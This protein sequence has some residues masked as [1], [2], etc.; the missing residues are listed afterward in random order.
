MR[1]CSALGYVSG[2]CVLARKSAAIDLIRRRKQYQIRHY[3]GDPVKFMPESS[4]AEVYIYTGFKPA[5]ADVT[6]KE[7]IVGVH[8]LQTVLFLQHPY[9]GQAVPTRLEEINAIEVERELTAFES[10][11]NNGICILV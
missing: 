4:I 2:L 5:V 9:S 8:V 1:C 3:C 6:K 7:G 10:A 11:D